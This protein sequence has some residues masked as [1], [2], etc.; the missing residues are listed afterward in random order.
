MVM[1]DP[2]LLGKYMDL[3]LTYLPR[4][5]A[6]ALLDVLRVLYTSSKPVRIVSMSGAQRGGPEIEPRR[7]SRLHQ[8]AR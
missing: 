4:G 1:Y 7:L 8:R 3:D 6:F 5:S 2:E